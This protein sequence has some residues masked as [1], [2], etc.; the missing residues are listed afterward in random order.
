MHLRHFRGDYLPALKSFLTNKSYTNFLAPSRGVDDAHND[1]SVPEYAHI[2]L[3]QSCTSKPT[4]PRVLWDDISFGQER[5]VKTAPD[6]IVG[7]DLT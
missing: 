3:A 2:R 6:K 1:S 7:N 4:V 5:S